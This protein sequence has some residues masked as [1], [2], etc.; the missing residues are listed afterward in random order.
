MS[1]CKLVI[2]NVRKP[3]KC[4]QTSMGNTV[5]VFVAVHD[6]QKYSTTWNQ[7]HRKREKGKVKENRLPALS[8]QRS[9]TSMY[10]LCST[11]FYCH[12]YVLLTVHPR[13]GLILISALLAKFSWL[14]WCRSKIGSQPIFKTFFVYLF[15]TNAAAAL[16]LVALWGIMEEYQTR[17]YSSQA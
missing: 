1:V 11:L 3:W 10:G 16:L 14:S 17:Y 4:Q 5:A 7:T 6:I 12:A 9:S 2:W 8:L 13:S 15:I